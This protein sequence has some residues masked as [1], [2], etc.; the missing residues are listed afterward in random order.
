[1]N[2]A[3]LATLFG[4]LFLGADAS[5]GDDAK[6]DLEKFQGTWTI[7]SFHSDGKPVPEL[8]GKKLKFSG[9]KMA[10]EGSEDM[11]R[12]FK[13]DTSTKP[14]EFDMVSED[15]KNPSAPP[16]IYEIDGDNLKVA[17][18]DYHDSASFDNKTRKLIKKESIRNKR[19]TSFDG[20]G[21]D[22]FV[23]KRGDVAV[24]SDEEKYKKLVVGKWKM[25]GGTA[26]IP[27][28]G[29]VEF[30]A[31]GKV[32]RLQPKNVSKEVG[33]YVIEGDYFLGTFPDGGGTGKDRKNKLLIE[34]LTETEFKT[35]EFEYK[36][37]K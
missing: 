35:Q 19:P 7:I 17:V 13:L 25:I 24:K 33:T 12:T 2:A 37:M 14:R 22:V 36:R 6:K 1:M 8:R 4:G 16:G 5:K 28:Y 21:A 32:L 10:L 3:Y 20:K 27:T 11:K 9:D 34:K 30:T 29:D 26:Y 23:L 31:D 15:P 18:A